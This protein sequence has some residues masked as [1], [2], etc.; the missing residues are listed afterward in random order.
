MSTGWKACA[1]GEFSAI[2]Q[3]ALLAI[4]IRVFASFMMTEKNGVFHG[5]KSP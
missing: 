2:L 3:E 4:T 5:L 1:T